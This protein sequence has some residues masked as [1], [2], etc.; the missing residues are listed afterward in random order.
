MRYEDQRSQSDFFNRSE[1]DIVRLVAMK[2]M[3]TK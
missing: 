3:P 2:P 1:M